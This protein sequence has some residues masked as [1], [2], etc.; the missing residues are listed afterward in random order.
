MLLIRDLESKISHL[1][2]SLQSIS[3][4]ILAN[5]SYES[6]PPSKLLADSEGYLSSLKGTADEVKNI[7]LVIKPE[8]APSI[9][10]AFKELM[11]PI[12]AFIRALKEAGETQVASKQLLEHLRSVVKS[13]QGFVELAREIA[14]NPSKGIMEVLRLREISETKNYISRIHLPEVVQMRL[15]YLKR[16]LESFKMH[17]SR[18]EESARD[19][20]KYIDWIE[21]EISR[22]QRQRQ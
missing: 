14:N 8:R 18:L 12:N 19:L 9:N 4:N 21:E 16:S 2:D 1:V 22:L 15:E 17:V 7:L 13:G 6:A 5:V 3:K 20:L 10:K 11:Q